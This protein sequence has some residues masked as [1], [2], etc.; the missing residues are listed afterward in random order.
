MSL[1]VACKCGQRFKADQRL[2]GK[3]VKCPNCGSPLAIPAATAPA[4]AA[5]PARAPAAKASEPQPLIVACACGARF[6]AKP[7]LAGRRVACPSCKQPLAIPTAQ[8][9]PAQSKPQ[10]A[11]PAPA[12]P[13]DDPLGPLGNP[14]SSS[15]WDDLPGDPLAGPAPTASKTLAPAALTGAKSAWSGGSAGGGRRK[16]GVDLL[17]S[18][19][20]TELFA[21]VILALLAIAGGLGLG[22]LASANYAA[23]QASAAW[24]SVNGTIN[25]AELVENGYSRRSG[26]KYKAVVQYSYTVGQTP[27][28][29]DR[30]AFDGYGS[31]FTPNQV[32]EKYAAGTTHPVFYD[33]TNPS[34]SVL[35]KGVT[36][37][38]FILP[39]IS[40]ILGLGGLGGLAACCVSIVYRLT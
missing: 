25:S 27:Y 31:S 26:K 34:S 23:S 8:S 38:N 19:S 30:I 10:P 21:G 18:R 36:A 40:A 16:M 29:G 17:P 39:V 1:E 4:T 3:K 35:E 33:P 7:E 28:M 32:V 2:A 20:T 15:F 37:S 12:V 24:P 6:Q 9:K 14:L 5:L 11:R 13:A 22:Y